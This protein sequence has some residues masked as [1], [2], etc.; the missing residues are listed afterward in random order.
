MPY[1]RFS[2]VAQTFSIPQNH[3]V[4]VAI[5]FFNTH[6]L[7]RSSRSHWF[8]FRVDGRQLG[9]NQ[10]LMFHFRV[11]RQTTRIALSSGHVLHLHLPWS[12]PNATTLLSRG[13]SCMRSS[14]GPSL[15]LLQRYRSMR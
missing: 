9:S 5:D 8:V 12:S 2:R 7:M 11:A 6:R 13:N 15:A 3:A 14:K 1:K 4:F 10:V